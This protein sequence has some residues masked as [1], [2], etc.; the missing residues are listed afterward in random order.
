MP[1]S[2][3][4]PDWPALLELWQDPE[5][6]ALLSQPASQD[7][8]MNP[9]IQ[10]LLSRTKKILVPSVKEDTITY[11]HAAAAVKCEAI[12]LLAKL[13]HLLQQQPILSMEFARATSDDPYDL[14]WAC[15]LESLRC[16]MKAIRVEKATL[17][18]SAPGIRGG[19]PRLAEHAVLEASCR[20]Q[21]E[22][23]AGKGAPFS[24]H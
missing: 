13:L 24:Y 15:V 21:L 6:Q 18:P 5:A 3:P 16:I 14:V 10:Q 12:A 7:A 22:E 11:K 8:F 4:E 20:Q 19:D 23:P 17:D 2:V 1:R 9:R